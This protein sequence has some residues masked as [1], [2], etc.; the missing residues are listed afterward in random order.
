[1]SFLK[2]EPPKPML[3]L[4]NLAPIRLSMPTARATSVTSASAFSQRA[5]MALIEEIL[6]ARKALETSLE[7]SLLQILEVMI[8]SRGTQFGVDL[9]QGLPGL[10]SAFR[11]PGADEDAVRLFQVADGRSFG[12]ELGIGE[13]VETDAVFPAVQDPFHGER[14]LHRQGALLDDD[15]GGFRKLKDLPGGLFPVLEIGGHPGPEPE[16]FGRRVHADEDDVVLP[17]PRF[18]IR[19]EEE[20]SPARLLQ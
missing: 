14:G 7:S 8:F 15:L 3:A 17:D 18:D 10:Q 12:Q 5:E 4:R 19:A 1:M 2:Q 6:W 16:G 9:R 11:F 13:D 20:I